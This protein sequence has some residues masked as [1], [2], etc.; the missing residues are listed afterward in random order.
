MADSEVK[1]VLTAEDNVTDVIK[2]VADYL[3]KDGL[4]QSITAVATS[5]LAMKAAVEVVAGA[6]ESVN[7][8]IAEGVNG[9][10]EAELV[11]KRLAMSMAA[12]GQYTQESYLAI[13]DWSDALEASTGVT[14]EE[15]K[16]LVSL[17]IQM[18]M[19]AEQ[20]RIAAQASLD[21]AA[22]TGISTDG[23]FR[24]LSITLSGTAGK[25]EKM[26]PELGSLTEAQLRNGDAITLIAAK[27][28]GFSKGSANTYIG[29]QKRIDNS[30]GDVK[31]AFGRLISQNPAYIAS[32]NAKADAIKVVADR[33]DSMA[34]W[35]LQN[36]DAIKAMMASVAAATAIVVTY[37]QWTNISI[38]SQIAWNTVIGVTTAVQKGLAL[39]T[40]ATTSTIKAQEIM[41][42]ASAAI[43][44]VLSGE[45][46]SQVVAEKSLQASLVIGLVVQKARQAADTAMIAIKGLLSAETI[47]NTAV[48]IANKVALIA[49]SAASTGMASVTGFLLAAKSALTLENLKNTAA[50]IANT[51]TTFAASAA[52]GALAVGIGLVTIA[53]NAL[54]VALTA[55]PIGLVVVAIAALSYG[56]YKLYQNFDLVTGAIKLG[57]GKALEWIMIPLSA[58]MNGVGVLVGAFNA[59]WGKSIQLASSRMNDYAKELQKSGQAQMDLANQAK[60]SGKEMDTAALMASRATDGLT[61]KIQAAAQEMLKLRGAFGT[62]MAGAATAFSA[63]KDL[64]PRMS[65]EM[66]NVDAKNWEKSINDLRKSAADLKIKLELQTQDAAVK[67]ELEKINQ[68]IRFAEEASKALR[69]KTA[70]ETRGATFKEEEIRLAQIKDKELSVSNEIMMMRIDNA[71][72]IRDRSVAIETERIMQMRGLG[73]QEAQAGISIKEEA[74]IAANQKEMAAFSNQLELQKQMAVGVESQKQLELANVKAAAMSGDTAGGMQAKNDVEMIQ[75]QQKAATLQQLRATDKITEAQYQDELTAIRIQAMTNRTN[76]EVA[77]NT[78]RA[79]LL[80]QTP[81]ALQLQ[82][83]NNRLQTEG[84]MLILQEKYASQQI[85]E[86]EFNAGAIARSEEMAA[87]QNEI[88]E[89]YLQKDVE[90]NQRLKDAWGTTLAQIR[91]EQEKHGQVMGTLQGITQSEQFKGMQ[92]ALA[93][94]STLMQSGSADMFRIGQA[95][96]IANAAVQI[97]Q[98]AIA[99]YTSM[100]SIP[101]VGPGLGIAAA[102]A[103]VAAGAMQIAKIK[104]QRPPGSTAHG[105][106][107]EV[108]KSMNNSTFLLKAG[109]RVVQPEQNKSLG[110][111][112]DKINSGGGS[113]GHTVNISVN[114]SADSSTIE[115]IKKAV[116]DG[117][118][119][120]SE[121]GVPVINSRGIVNA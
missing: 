72:A 119:E 85:T 78:Q 11:N 5:F 15:T 99:A 88:K 52:T 38:A 120:A 67:A 24:Q 91:L 101:F 39:Q 27:Y 57:L 61:N 22:A 8:V 74:M 54:N 33:L 41:D 108:P 48:E 37:A 104:A 50:T 4:G 13:N 17:G 69:I 7:A 6:L 121:R 95:A 51:V 81:E 10:A 100:A 49:S 30:I 63:L 32:M 23:A 66:F 98:S 77:L 118:R 1:L 68:Q 110:E 56:I 90:K 107:D 60:T 97:P 62:A 71:K 105:G 18:G 83:E 58:L 35:A 93:N 25:M 12:V 89:A 3:G 19:T 28:D 76:M 42:R 115:N 82:L 16:S 59:D 45:I 94:T 73:T 87:R 96:A 103:A 43:K 92:T 106:L 14:A 44:A 47:K 9:A 31:E 84:E 29:A 102:A 64:S 21:L 34:T 80:G 53:Q 86:E 75:A 114:G 36:G 109:E 46:L 117:L 111:A 2:K 40:V 116:M 26:I 70:Q 55:N 113:G 79:T 65:L 112:I 20:A